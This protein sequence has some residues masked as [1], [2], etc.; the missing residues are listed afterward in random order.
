MRMHA[1][2][3]AALAVLVAGSAFSAEI[4]VG[5]DA[6]ELKGTKWITKDGT[7]P[8]FKDKVRVI[9]FWFAT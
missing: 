8:V 9:D 4:E 1:F 3:S 2:G 5:K 6:P 7:D